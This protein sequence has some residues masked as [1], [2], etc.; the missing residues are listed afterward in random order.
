MASKSLDKKKTPLSLKLKKRVKI[1]KGEEE[2]IR[3]ESIVESLKHIN[4]KEILEIYD[5][6]ELIEDLE[7]KIYDSSNI[8]D[9]I[10]ENITNFELEFITA[11]PEEKQ[12]I[13]DSI[14]LKFEKKKENIIEVTNPVDL[15]YKYFYK[16]SG[17]SREGLNLKRTISTS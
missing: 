16:S 11:D 8:E 15:P 2:R 6:T 1:E 3:K 14:K 4:R 10:L 17:K 5:N 12:Q 7:V 13:I 9:F